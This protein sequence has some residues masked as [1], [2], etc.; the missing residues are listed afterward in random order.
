[1]TDDR[2]RTTFICLTYGVLIPTFMGLHSCSCSM[3]GVTILRRNDNIRPLWNGALSRE[4]RCGNEFHSEKEPQH[5]YALHE[6]I[7]KAEDRDQGDCDNNKE[8]RGYG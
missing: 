8:L 7:V 3:P 4:A 6:Y 1:M 5:V 2:R